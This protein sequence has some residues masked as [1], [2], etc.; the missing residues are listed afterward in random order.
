MAT[1]SAIEIRK[2][3]EDEIASGVQKPGTRLEEIALADRFGVSR[4]PIR[5]ALRLLDSSGLI[6]VR[7]RRGA[8]V[9]APTLDRLVDMFE[10]MAE[11]EAICGR[12][13]AQRMSVEERGALMAQHAVCKAACESRN[14]DDYYEANA[15]YHELIYAGTHNTFLSDEVRQLRRRLRA[16]RRLQLRARDR[17]NDSLAEHA[18][19]TN[20]IINMNAEEA[21]RLLHA[22]V[23]I[24]GNRF[25][26]WL[27]T[28]NK[29]HIVQELAD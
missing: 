11:M 22:H 21:G 25:G 24:Q 26:E 20:A 13:A 14:V 28:L 1:I 16:Y 2:I 23:S 12:L 17:M 27:K 15:L 29:A 8:I 6:E 19:I 7:P 5:E 10:V 4:T 18:E 9:A 3:L